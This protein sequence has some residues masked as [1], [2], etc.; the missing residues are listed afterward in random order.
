MATY[1]LPDMDFFSSQ[2]RS[3][4]FPCASCHVTWK[5]WSDW[6]REVSQEE[7]GQLSSVVDTLSRHRCSACP[8][9][10][11][12]VGMAQE[13]QHPQEWE[14]GLDEANALHKEM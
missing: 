2:A 9:P 4:R 1:P 10:G 14:G 11:V 6:P 12:G 8:V 13:F 7:A 3:S 5:R